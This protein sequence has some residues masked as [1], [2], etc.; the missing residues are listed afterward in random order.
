MSMEECKFSLLPNAL[1]EIIEYGIKSDVDN[2]RVT[3]AAFKKSLKDKKDRVDVAFISRIHGEDKATKEVKKR[4]KSIGIKKNCS[5]YIIFLC[6]ESRCQAENL[7]LDI[8]KKFYYKGNKNDCKPV[9][10][11]IDNMGSLK[12]S[13][14]KSIKTCNEI[15]LFNDGYEDYGFFHE[16]FNQVC[17]TTGKP[18]SGKVNDVNF[19]FKLISLGTY[20]SNKNEIKFMNPTVFC[21][22]IPP[23]TFIA[24]FERVFYINTLSSENIVSI[25]GG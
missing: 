8:V 13:L 21:I 6:G 11:I 20:A 23:E 14:V 12:T 17:I 25:I 16:V 9:T 18:L 22:D 2:R 10:F 3:T 5:E 1:K 15:I 19:N 7:M 4:M 24:N